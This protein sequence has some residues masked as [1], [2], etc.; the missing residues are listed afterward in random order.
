MLEAYWDDDELVEGSS[1]LA[2]MVTINKDMDGM[3]VYVPDRLCDD[4]P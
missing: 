1:R 2:S 3:V 4:I